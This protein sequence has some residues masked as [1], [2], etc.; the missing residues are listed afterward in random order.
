MSSTETA[1]GKSRIVLKVA[2]IIPA[3]AITP[4]QSATIKAEVTRQAQSETMAEYLVA[5]QERFG[6]TINN[7]DTGIDGSISGTIAPIFAAVAYAVSGTDTFT[8]TVSGNGSFIIAG[9]PAGSY[10]VCIHP[11]L[12]FCKKHK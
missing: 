7:T 9:V 10:T 11:L 12:L 6:V 3:P 5:L 4:E 2:E 1:D 8:T